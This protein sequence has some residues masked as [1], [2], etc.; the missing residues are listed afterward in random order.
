MKVTNIRIKCSKPSTKQLQQLCNRI[1]RETHKLGF[2]LC[3][4][5]INSTRIDIVGPSRGGPKVIADDKHYNVRLN[6]FMPPKRTDSPTWNQYVVLNNYLNNTF[7]KLKISATITSLY[8]TI[9]KDTTVYD[10]HDWFYQKPSWVCHNE[11]QGYEVIS[12]AEF[13]DNTG[14]SILEY[15]RQKRNERAR[16]NRRRRKEAQAKERQQTKLNLIV[17]E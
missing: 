17:N 3:A 8:Y 13:M 2:N 11:N 7:D 12:Q 1:E 10:E 9:R 4:N 14:V 6:P 16:E 5:I 15:Q